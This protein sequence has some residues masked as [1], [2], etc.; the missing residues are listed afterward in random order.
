[1]CLVIDRKLKHMENKF[2]TIPFKNVQNFVSRARVCLKVG[3]FNDP[4]YFKIA[5][6]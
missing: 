2:K 1:M 3:E 5:K 6:F 4:C